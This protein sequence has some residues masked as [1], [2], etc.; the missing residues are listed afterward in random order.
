MK[1]QEIEYQVVSAAWTHHNGAP[2]LAKLVQELAASG[3]EPI[4]GVAC[5]E[6]GVG[7]M[8]YQAMIRKGKSYFTF[9][10][11]DKE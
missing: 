4:G 8:M 2:S 3:W 6:A 1:V 5:I 9:P 11:K 7:A 10:E